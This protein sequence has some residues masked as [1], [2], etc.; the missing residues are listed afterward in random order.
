MEQLTDKDAWQKKIFDDSIVSKW[1][2][3]ALKI[4]DR[5]LWSLVTSGKRQVYHEDGSLAIQDHIGVEAVTPLTRIMSE[6]VFDCGVTD[7]IDKWSSKGNMISHPETEDCPADFVPAEYWSDTCQWLP[8]NLA[9]QE[10]GSVKFTSYINNLH[11]TKYEDIY[12]AIENLIAVALPAW[13]LC[14]TLHIDPDVC[15]GPDVD[16]ITREGAGKMTSR[17][18]KTMPENMD[19]ENADLWIP[20]NPQETAERDVDWDYL[21]REQKPNI[22]EPAFEDIDYV[23]KHHRLKDRFKESGLQI[24]VKMAS[25]EL[26]PEKPEFPGGS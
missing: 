25:T 7:A 2:E 19:D 16:P 8:A 17:F 20:S 5:D 22:P 13:D 6:T 1:R 23:P 10:D 14:L 18:S 26:T 24:I 3:E 12:S 9:F 11:P 15:L 4:P 21:L